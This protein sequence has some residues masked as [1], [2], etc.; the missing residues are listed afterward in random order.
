MDNLL[1]T[2]APT[3]GI[4]CFN[5]CYA[6]ADDVLNTQAPTTGIACCN[7]CYARADDVQ[8]HP[9]TYKM[10]VLSAVLDTRSRDYSFQPSFQDQPHN[11]KLGNK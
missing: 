4:A 8:K 11:D 9:S 7:P 5:P 1:N 6:R 3:T 10:Q 2:Q